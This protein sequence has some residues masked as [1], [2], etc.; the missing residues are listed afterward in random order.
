M[1]AETVALFAA[2]TRLLRRA[3]FGGLFLGA[4]AIVSVGSARANSTTYQVDITGGAGVE[5][6]IETITGTITTDGALGYLQP[7][8]IL[9]WSLTASGVIP[10]FAASSDPGAND[11][12]VGVACLYAV[13]NEISLTGGP[14]CGITDFYG[15]DP[16]VL[17]EI[18]FSEDPCNVVPTTFFLG[19]PNGGDFFDVTGGSIVA[20]PTNP[21]VP[22]PPTILLLVIGLA[23]LLF[24]RKHREGRKATD[25]S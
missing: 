5:L 25:K 13:G 17:N 15:R 22:E 1:L 11:G 16:N 24:V 2:M 9:S 3:A 7:A 20:A 18:G 21:S 19:L 8:D 10:L 4:L 23:A 14:G 12:C 6:D